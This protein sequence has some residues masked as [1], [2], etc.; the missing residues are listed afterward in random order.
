ME[1]VI[2]GEV[3]IVWVSYGVAISERWMEGGGKCTAITVFTRNN[4]NQL[5]TK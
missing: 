2:I 4:K 3:Q 1:D 5:V